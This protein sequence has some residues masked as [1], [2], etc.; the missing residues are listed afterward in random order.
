MTADL[1]ERPRSPRQQRHRMDRRAADSD[2]LAADADVVQAWPL[3][4]VEMSRLQRREQRLGVE[5]LGLDLDEAAERVVFAM[6]EMGVVDGDRRQ[7]P[8]F[9]H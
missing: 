1:G 6:A 8:A 9:V 7:A 2:F 5:A 4:G 3:A